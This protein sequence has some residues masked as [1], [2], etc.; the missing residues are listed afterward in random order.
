MHLAGAYHDEFKRVHVPQAGH[1]H[2]AKGG[3][4]LLAHLVRILLIK[5]VRFKEGR[6]E[7]N[8]YLEQWQQR[9][10]RTRAVHLTGPQQPPRIH[11]APIGAA[12]RHVAVRLDEP[13]VYHTHHVV[14]VVFKLEIPWFLGVGYVGRG[15]YEASPRMVLRHCIHHIEEMA[16]LEQLAA[17]AAAHVHKRPAD[18]VGDGGRRWPHHR[19]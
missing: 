18:S 15:N 2:H 14:L 10:L 3:L 6:G 17:E 7:P 9:I 5:R 4:P 11:A 16:D 13:A 8:M 12:Q 1:S 19:P